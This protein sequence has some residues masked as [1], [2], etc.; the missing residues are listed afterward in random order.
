MNSL[1]MTLLTV[2]A[3]VMANTMLA[4]TP[5]ANGL[6][7]MP[8]STWLAMGKAKGQEYLNSACQFGKTVFAQGQEWA[9]IAWQAAANSTREQRLNAASLSILGCAGIYGFYT[10]AK[11]KGKKVAF[12]AAASL[13]LVAAV[14]ATRC[15]QKIAEYAKEA[16][17]G[18]KQ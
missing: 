17:N 10:L 16:F 11:N 6:P 12:C 14:V 13:G 2:V 9:N 5:A 18:W 1:R 4:D 3:V 8:E 15:D 7:S